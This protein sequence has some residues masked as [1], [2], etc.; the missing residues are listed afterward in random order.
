MG[1]FERLY[2][3]SHAVII[4][5]KGSGDRVKSFQFDA[6]RDKIIF[7]FNQD[8]ISNSNEYFM[9]LVNKFPKN[10][11]V[12]FSRLKRK[13]VVLDGSEERAFFFA[14]LLTE[15]S[16]IESFGENGFKWIFW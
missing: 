7:L 14:Q 9:K 10:E 12:D 1:R 5:P 2:E 3:A 13:D 4:Y 6:T 11:E 16:R 15:I 8:G